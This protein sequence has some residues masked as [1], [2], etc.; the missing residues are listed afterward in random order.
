MKVALNRLGGKP[1][2]VPVQNQ[3]HGRVAVAAWSSAGAFELIEPGAWSRGQY[4]GSWWRLPGVDVV[5]QVIGHGVCLITVDNPEHTQFL[6][7]F[8][9]YFYD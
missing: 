8:Y 9:F 4:R 7:A 3:H 1:C 5:D 2:S 6:P